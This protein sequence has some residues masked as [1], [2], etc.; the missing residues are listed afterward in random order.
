M[1]LALAADVLGLFSRRNGEGQGPIEDHQ[2]AYPEPLGLQRHAATEYR[3]CW[4]DI[5]KLEAARRG[6]PGH[7]PV[8]PDQLDP[9]EHV[10]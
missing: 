5:R 4:Q 1:G 2:R 8:G 9:R 10:G 7:H 6:C 3:V